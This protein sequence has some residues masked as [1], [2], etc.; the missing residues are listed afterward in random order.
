MN[1]PVILAAGTPQM[2]LPYDNAN[3]FVRRHGAH[4]G[5]LASWTAWVAP[6]TMRPKDVAR[7]HGMN[8]T[9][10]R[11]LNRIPPR[12]L[13]KA[14]STLLVPRSGAAQRR[15]V[16]ARRRQ[17]HDG[18]RA[19]CP[20]A[21][22]AVA[23]GRQARHVASSRGATGSAPSRSPSG[24]T[25]R[26]RAVSRRGRRSSSSGSTGR[27]HLQASECFSVARH[28]R[29]AGQGR[30][31]PSTRWPGQSRSS[32]CRQAQCTASRAARQ[33]PGR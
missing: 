25:C 13:I 10:L 22:P 27:F 8:E 20:A 26:R 3:E 21:A 32:G 23:A 24:T 33:Q 16:R 31:C 14:G 30:S 7:K 4:T 15:R 19:R 6:K 28:G 18:A 17:R 29:Q 9:A 5:P 12:M 2:L 1:K 11:E